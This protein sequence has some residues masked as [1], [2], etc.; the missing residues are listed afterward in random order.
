M[1][2][3]AQTN[4]QLLNQLQ[5]EGYSNTE[6]GLICKAYELALHLYAGLYRASGKSALTHGV[7]TASILGSLHLPAD[8]VA[9]GLI[10]N[11]YGAGDFGDG[12]Q[13]ISEAKRKQVRQAVGRTVEECVYRFPILRPNLLA[14]GERL[15]ALGPI[16]R[17]VVL[18]HL[19][20][21]LEKHLEFDI[22]Y[23]GDVKRR[24]EEITQNGLHL[25]AMTE[26]LGFPTLAAELE[27]ALRETAS[28][29]IPEQLRRLTGW[30]SSFRIAPRSYRRRLWPVVRQELIRGLQYLRSTISV[31]KCLR[32]LNLG[33]DRLRS[34][35]GQGKRFR[36]GD[37]SE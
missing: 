6:L 11:V 13:E 14:I 30:N 23:D 24:R 21:T 32:K 29:E 35:I 3:Y 16:D 25:V 22:L 7:G 1:R 33:L 15:D 36:S 27:E 10:H 5:R 20:E 12:C 19:A 8:V 28:T 18:L 4:L 9:A 2:S 37:L 31:S 26:K 17:H 34:V